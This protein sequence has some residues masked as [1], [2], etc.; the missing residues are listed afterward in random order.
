MQFAKALDQGPYGIGPAADWGRFT[1][2][3][4][5]GPDQYAMRQIDVF[6]CGRFLRYDREHWV[7]AF[8]MLA[9]A[10]FK[11]PLTLSRHWQILAIEGAEFETEWE[12]AGRSPQWP[13]QVASAAMAQQGPVPIWLR[14]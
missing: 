9:D 10:R 8:G 4:E 7:D 5:V 1:R 2:L 12:A 6:E 3:I 14:S 13:L 11:Q